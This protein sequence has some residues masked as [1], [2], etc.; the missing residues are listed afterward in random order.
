MSSG[1]INN[2]EELTVVANRL[3]NRHMNLA[4]VGV[5]LRD[6]Y[7]IG[8]VK[9]KFGKKLIEIVDFR[10]HPEVLPYLRKMV[11]ISEHLKKLKDLRAKIRLHNLEYRLKKILRKRQNIVRLENW[12]LKQ[13]DFVLGKHRL[14]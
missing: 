1:Q 7:G 13:N 11:K 3:Y 9:A 4:T 8:S 6:E 2:I 12:S 10:I 14:Y 5:I